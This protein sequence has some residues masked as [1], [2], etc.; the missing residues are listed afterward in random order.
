MKNVLFT[1]HS[2]GGAVASLLYLRYLFCG[3]S[4]YP[5]LRF[6]C[7][8]F[9]SPPVLR[10]EWPPRHCLVANDSLV[11]NIINE[12]DLVTRIDHP[13]IRTLVDLYRSIYRLP[14]I[15]EVDSRV[16]GTTLESQTSSAKDINDQGEVRGN[17]ARKY[18]IVPKPEYYHVGK[19]V[20]LK[21]S[22]VRG[23]YG[24]P[25]SNDGRKGHL[26]L[27]ASC[28]PAEEFAKLLFCRVAVHSRV[29]YEERVR[30]ISE[31]CFN[32]RNGW[33]RELGMSSV[34]IQ[35]SEGSGTGVAL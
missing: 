6:S 16:T 15:Q 12:Y 7:I 4:K 34:T 14:P 9:G 23:Q 27:N 33:F 25:E 5:L 20:V 30:L 3:T 10:P 22:F 13:Y 18:W 1:G 11:L 32:G 2:A 29:C 26:V 8:T 19:R 24:D 28:I 35:E 31:G 21:L 17:Q